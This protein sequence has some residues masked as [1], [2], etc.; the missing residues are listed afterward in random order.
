MYE[1]AAIK[2][3]SKCLTLIDRSFELRFIA[4]KNGSAV[5]MAAA[6]KKMRTM[7]FQK[8]SSIVRFLSGNELGYHYYLWM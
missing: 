2:R 1:N 4:F 5:C 6:V 3:N 8:R 7:L